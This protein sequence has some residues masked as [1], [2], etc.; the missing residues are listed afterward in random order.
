MV[1]PGTSPLPSSLSPLSPAMQ[2]ATNAR[3]R[4]GAPGRQGSLVRAVF[5]ADR[6]CRR[7][8]G[9]R[10]FAAASSVCGKCAAGGRLLRAGVGAAGVRTFGTIVCERV[11]LYANSSCYN[12]R[13][14]ASVRC[15][16]GI[17]I[18]LCMPDILEASKLG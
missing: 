1:H 10:S 17:R 3:T 12:P 16:C 11:V 8:K 5:V 4:T 13:C 15:G 2:L 18:A 7:M 14:R 9:T 6:S